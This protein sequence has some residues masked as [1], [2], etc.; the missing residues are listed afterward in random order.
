M[1]ENLVLSLLSFLTYLINPPVCSLP[2]LSLPPPQQRCP[3]TPP[4]LSTCPVLLSFHSVCTSLFA[5][6]LFSWSGP[7]HLTS[8]TPFG[9]V[10]VFSSAHLGFGVACQATFLTLLGS[11]TSLHG[12]NALF[13]LPL[14]LTLHYRLPYNVDV[15]SLHKGSY[16]Y[17]GPP[18][19]MDVF[20]TPLML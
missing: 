15:F 18:C 19:G 11:R 10:G 16:I 9:M 20:I 8:V 6:N 13:Y 7:W 1:N 12:M 3:L 14:G 4:R 2:F 17:I 5:D